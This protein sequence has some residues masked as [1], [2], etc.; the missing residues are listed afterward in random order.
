MRRHA[1]SG[2]RLLVARHERQGARRAS[3]LYQWANNSGTVD[4]RREPASYNGS[5]AVSGH[6]RS[7]RRGQSG[8]SHRGASRIGGCCQ[9]RQVDVLCVGT[10]SRAGGSQP[11]S[12]ERQQRAKEHAAGQTAERRRDDGRN[13]GCGCEEGVMGWCA[14]GRVVGWTAEARGRARG[15]RERAGEAAG[16]GGLRPPQRS[17]RC[18]NP[19]PDLGALLRSVSQDALADSPDPGPGRR[20]GRRRRTKRSHRATFAVV[21]AW[22]ALTQQPIATPPHPPPFAGGPPSLACH[23]PELLRGAARAFLPPCSVPFRMDAG[24]AF[25]NE[26][27]WCSLP[28]V[29][30]VGVETHNWAKKT[31]RAAA[32]E[33]EPLRTFRPVAT[34]PRTAVR[35]CLISCAVRHRV[36]GM[37]R[38]P[39]A[40][41]EW[42]RIVYFFP[43]CDSTPP[44]SHRPSLGP[45]LASV[46]RCRRPRVY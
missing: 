37:G 4:G 3:A 35:N 23:L 17:P 21:H 10:A 27:G 14:K 38:V 34:I 7:L 46:H 12:G 42:C 1:R 13:D 24:P 28:S 33:A 43:S 15:R 31:C 40:G 44:I 11:D 20:R 36:S 29:K 30:A 6:G 16:R 2:R 19:Y 8:R 5:G 25:K 45:S 9:T 18:Q 32:G 22:P 26:S 41:H 39:K